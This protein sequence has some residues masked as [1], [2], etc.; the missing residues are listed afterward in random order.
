MIGV[1][2]DGAINSAT[3]R[4]LVARVWPRRERSCVRAGGEVE[5][6]CSG[7]EEWW[8]WEQEESGSSDWEDLK[9]Q[10]IAMVSQSRNLKIWDS[11]ERKHAKIC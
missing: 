6:E 3:P 7:E 4:N 8:E 10:D 1:A 9:S 2:G 5:G 11:V